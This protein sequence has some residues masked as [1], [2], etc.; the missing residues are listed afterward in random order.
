MISNRRFEVSNQTKIK[1]VTGF[2][3][4]RPVITTPRDTL[5]WF[6]FAATKPTMRKYEQTKGRSRNL[7]ALR[8]NEAGQR[9]EGARRRGTSGLE[10]EGR[11]EGSSGWLATEH[12]WP[13]FTNE[14]NRDER[15]R[16]H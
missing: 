3:L 15:C 8:N 7:T 13:R 4:H 2:A 12:L 6:D 14:T 10:A 16:K 11:M 1:D 9:P 5:L